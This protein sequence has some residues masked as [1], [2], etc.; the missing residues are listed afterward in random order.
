M[1]PLLLFSFTQSKVTQVEKKRQ[2]IKSRVDG[3][4]RE[5]ESLSGDNLRLKEQV[6]VVGRA[7]KEQEV[8]T[9]KCDNMSSGQYLYGLKWH[10]FLFLSF[11]LSLF[12]SE[13]WTNSNSRKRSK[14][15]FRRELIRQKQCKGVEITLHLADILSKAT[16]NHV[17]F[18]HCRSSYR[19]QLRVKCLAQ[20]HID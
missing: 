10:L 6:K 20:R 5:Q 8:L 17:T 13:L 19:E 12:I 7:H 9:G 3:M 14:T 4:R 16:C 2:L 15:V 1:H 11:S 18:I